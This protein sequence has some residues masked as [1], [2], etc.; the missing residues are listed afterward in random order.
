MTRLAAT[1]ATCPPCPC[2]AGGRSCS[3]RRARCCSPWPGARWPARAPPPRSR[4]R[5][6]SPSAPA[7]AP[8]LVVHVAGAV[9]Q[10]G[11]YRLAEGKRVADAVARAGGATAP[12][13]TAAINLA[14]PL[15]DGMQVVVPSRVAG[16][17][18]RRR[19]RGRA[20]TAARVSLE[21]GDVR[22]ARRPAGR[23]PGHR[24]EDRRL[25]GRARRLPLRRR[26]RRDPRHRPGADRAAA[27]A[28]VA[29]IERALADAAR[30]SRPASGWRSRT[31]S[32]AAG[33]GF[34]A[35]RLVV[36][37]AAASRCPRRARL[38]ALRAGARAR[39]LVVGKRRGSTRSTAALLE[40]ELGRSG[41]V[42]ARSSPARRG[43]RGSRCACPPRCAASATRS[44]G[45]RVLLEL[46][47]RPLAAAGRRPRPPRDRVDAPRG[48][49]DGFDERGWLARRGVHVVL[50]GGD[51]R[52]V[53][54]RGGIGGVSDRLRAHVARAIAPGLEGER[55]AVLAGIVL[56]E[57]EGLSEE[58]RDSFKASG[59][60]PPPGR[61]GAEHHVP[62]ARRARA[63]VAARASRG[64]RPRSSRSR[65][66]PPT[67]SRSA[68][69]PP[70]SAPASP[71]GSPR[72]PGC[73]RG[74]A[75]A[76]TSSRS[77]RRS[78]SPGRPPACSSPA[79][80]SRSP[81][82]RRSSCC[83]PRLAACARG[84]PAARWLREALAVS[85]ACGVGDGA[86]PVA[87][88]RQRPGLLAARERAR[89]ARDRRRCSGSRS[90]AR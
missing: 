87:P 85:T 80:S 65:R 30:R 76:G 23:R 69:S 20:P 86:D 24:A 3:R 8:K 47:R 41:R 28:G 56:G 4:P 62:R 13:D 1:L 74:R 78:C 64:S 46:P 45:E 44:L 12:A 2:R 81:P 5:R 10:P 67:C 54:R 7:A 90:S 38:P 9:R 83:V 11:L 53:G 82:S 26:S 84:L 15:A 58:L 31:P 29:V 66:S 22:G 88:V 59:P 51:W 61:L 49:E 18:R 77:A 6:S 52:I 71:A 72:S 27:G 35:R 40:P 33:A 34:G 37:A 32:R 39:R 14:A 21:L 73:S 60:L 19:R 79:S 55:R 42:D 57:D 63:R 25:P 36:L 50:H 75:T 70:S 48:P 89:H 16:A 43:G 68:G 17:G